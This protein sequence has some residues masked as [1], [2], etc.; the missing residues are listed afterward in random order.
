MFAIALAKEHASILQTPVPFVFVFVCTPGKICAHSLTRKNLH[1]SLQGGPPQKLPQGFMEIAR[2]TG[3]NSSAGGVRS[4]RAAHFTVAGP[5]S[6]YTRGHHEC[7]M[8]CPT[9]SNK[10][11]SCYEATSGIKISRRL[12]EAQDPALELYV[13]PV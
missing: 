10:A 5:S 3:A 4:T 9:T 12:A 7:S 1:V 2:S 11:E 8:R 13:A 6:C